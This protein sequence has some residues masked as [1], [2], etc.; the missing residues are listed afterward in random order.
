VSIQPSSQPPEYYNNGDPFY[1]VYTDQPPFSAAAAAG[2]ILALLGVCTVVGGP[3][4]AALG[5]LARARIAAG[6]SR[7]R[8][9]ATAA[10]VIGWLVTL[11]WGCCGG[12]V[13]LAFPHQMQTLIHH[14]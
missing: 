3:I 8:R 11:S 6:H 9:T 2:L 7:G 12:V 5:Y 13:W 14:L 10:I 4:G 1:A